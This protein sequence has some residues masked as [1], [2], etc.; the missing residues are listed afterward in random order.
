MSSDIVIR[1]ATAS[2]IRRLAALDSAAA[3]SG[4]ALV[5]VVDGEARAAISFDGSSILANPFF[6]TAHM[7]ELLRLRVAQLQPEA[8]S[9]VARLRGWPRATRS[10][11][12]RGTSTPHSATA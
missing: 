12:S 9:R 5:A 4:R 3:P 1:E 11:A 8:P 6:R 7:I 2:E 10:T